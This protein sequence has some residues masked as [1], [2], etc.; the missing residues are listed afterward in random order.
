M[1]GLVVDFK[2]SLPVFDD[3]G[4]SLIVDSDLYMLRKDVSELN[5]SL[6]YLHKNSTKLIR[7][8]ITDKLHEAME[9]YE[10]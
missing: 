5:E 3:D 4:K 2:T 9:P 6:D 1:K 8:I 7:S 10:I